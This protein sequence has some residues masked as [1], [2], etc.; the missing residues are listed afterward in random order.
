MVVVVVLGLSQL[1]INHPLLSNLCSSKIL[2][3]AQQ[4]NESVFNESENV[5]KNVLSKM[6]SKKAKGAEYH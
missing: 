6:A 2:L 4:T 1:T 3:F 5:I